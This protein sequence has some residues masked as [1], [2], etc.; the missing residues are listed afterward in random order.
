[1]D[2]REEV[3]KFAD[4]ME[5][6]LKENDYKGGWKNCDIAFLV[7]KL[8]EEVKEL[9]DA[10]CYGTPENV[11]SEAADIGNIAMMIADIRNSL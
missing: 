1:M 8:H 9:I 3:K 7:D 2:V 11:L 5:A 6:E 4:A 10:I